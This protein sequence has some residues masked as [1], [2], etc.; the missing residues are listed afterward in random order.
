DA[1]HDDHRPPW[2]ALRRHRPR[3]RRARR[4][5][6]PRAHRP[7]ALRA[8]DGAARLPHHGRRVRRQAGRAVGVHLRRRGRRG[9]R[10]PRRLPHRRG[11]RAD[12]PD[13]R[14]QPRARRGGDRRDDLR[15]GRRAHPPH[16][17]RDLPHRRGTRRGD[18]ERHGIRRQRGLRAPRRTP[19]PL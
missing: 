17:P 3:V 4:G 18:G 1:P 14:V 16:Q 9:I 5:G 8:M 6:L 2:S 15:G 19:R 10:L 13:L 11:R 7:R 12:H